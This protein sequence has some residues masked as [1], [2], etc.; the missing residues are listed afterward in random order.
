MWADC[1]AFDALLLAVRAY[2][3]IDIRPCGEMDEHPNANPE[4]RGL[5]TVNRYGFGAPGIIF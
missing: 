5:W 1:A 4:G 2:D 3:G